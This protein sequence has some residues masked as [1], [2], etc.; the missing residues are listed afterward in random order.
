LFLISF[1]ISIVKAAD[2]S[3]SVPDDAQK[4]DDSSITITVDQYSETIA[5][6]TLDSWVVSKNSFS[7]SPTVKAEFENTNYCP[8]NNIFCELTL[9]ASERQHIHLAQQTT[10]NTDLIRSYVEDLARKVNRD[11]TDAKFT[12]E[13]GK[14]STFTE[15][16]NG[17]ALDVDKSIETISSALG[18]ISSSQTISLPFESKKS[19]LD[20]ADVNNM[21]ISSLIG[22]GTSNFKGSPKNRIHNIE[23]GIERFNGTLIKPGEEFSFVKTLGDVDADHG[24]LPEL[25]IKQGATE[26]E[27]GGGICQVSTTAFRAAIYSGLKITARRNHAY[28]VSYYN[29]QG[30]DATVYVP[31]PDLKFINNTPGYILIQTKIE[32]TILTF[33]FYGT[34][35]GRKTTIDGPTITE[36]QPDGSLKATFT[37]HV[38]DASGKEFITDVFNSSYNSPYLYPHP[39][40]LVLTVKPANWSKDEW[41]AYQKM[42]KDMANAPAKKP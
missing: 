8:V 31:E 5:K 29:P 3:S 17:I 30:M 13:D 36:R 28:P 35:D 9:T 16:Q 11:P 25:V 42:I 41:K 10:I 20:Y 15:S 23:V 18:N 1:P 4:N 2:T 22:E 21:G 19:D 34:D 7:L 14:V 12:I 40:G 39:G 26:P 38:V 33:D 6:D 27:F 37:Q 32:G 24:Y